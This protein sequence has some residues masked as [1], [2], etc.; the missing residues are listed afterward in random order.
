MTVTL[1]PT[2]KG[3]LRITLLI[4]NIHQ[5]LGPQGQREPAEVSLQ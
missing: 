3:H 2:V 4:L 1:Y 5:E